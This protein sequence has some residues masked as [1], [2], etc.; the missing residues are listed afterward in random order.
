MLTLSHMWHVI[1]TLAN[2]IGFALSAQLNFALSQRVTFSDRRNSTSRASKRWMLFNTSALVALGVNTVVFHVV[3]SFGAM[4]IIA[5]SIA[6][7]TGMV[8]NF[9]MNS[10]LTFR[11]P[12]E[13]EV[14][15]EGEEL[16]AIG[17][18]VHQHNGIGL[19][20]PAYGEAG[21]L[22][23]VIGRAVAYFETH[24]WPYTITIV[25][26]GSPDNTG[27]VA[28][29]LSEQH[30]N[31]RV[32]HHE[33]NR[34]YGGALKTGFTESAFNTGHE[35]VAFYDSDD[36]FRPHSL[37]TLLHGMA[38][39][40]SDFSI[41]YRIKR[42]DSVV[43]LAMGRGWHWLSSRVLGYRAIDVDCGFKV[44]RAEMIRS[45]IGELAGENATISPELITRAQRKNYT[46]TEV[47][48]T[49]YPRGEGEQTGAN[50]KV[51]IRSIQQ[52]FELRKA[53]RNTKGVT[54][55]RNDAV[56]VAE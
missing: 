11:R 29:A 28:T 4:T 34:G 18:F 17:R 44:F 38:Q 37:G 55:V 24:G 49:H 43:R 8:V 25:N 36:Q 56:A 51:V 32:V 6:V 23:N 1:P 2:A 48:L 54:G 31:V 20:F 3:F 16:Q 30:E 50:F 27:E 45:L 19:F 22:P 39:H 13:T 12:Q 26:D 5:S 21:N 9:A 40:K 14:S 47:G 46:M 42:A 53:V 52:L 33:V 41:G 10:R 35:L 15:P 7:L